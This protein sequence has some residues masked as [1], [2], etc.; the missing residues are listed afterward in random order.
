MDK[1]FWNSY[2][3]QHAKDK[4]IRNSSSFAEFCFKKFFV[5]KNLRIIEL[6]AGNGRDAIFFA[7][8]HINV[9]AID[10]SADAI[11]HE[12][13]MLHP[14]YSQYLDCKE[15]D[16]VNE[17]YTKYEPIDAF[18]S[19]FTIHS[20]TQKNEELLLPKLYQSL[21]QNGL[22]CIEVRTINDPI[23]GQG[24][25]I[26]KDTYFTDHKRRFINSKEFLA[27]ALKLGFHLVYF[28][29][30]NNLSVYKDDNPVLMRIIL[31]K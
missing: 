12:K 5:K 10:Q 1:Q 21:K 16:F 31:K 2:Y 7:R 20:I 9:L 26:D 14:D 27:K 22:L 8:K 19:R 11:Q 17:D 6:G 4:E 30:E 15:L 3:H 13:D 18:Y 25:Y 24:E 23:Y 29:E 28:T